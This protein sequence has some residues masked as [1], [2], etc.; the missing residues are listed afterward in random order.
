MLSAALVLA[1]VIQVAQAEVLIDD[2]SPVRALCLHS[3]T[4]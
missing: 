1:R 3:F 2:R 4:F